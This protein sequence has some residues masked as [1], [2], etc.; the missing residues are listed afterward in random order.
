MVVKNYALIEKWVGSK[1]T[2]MKT[3]F[4]AIFDPSWTH[5]LSKKSPNK[6]FFKQHFS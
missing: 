1:V 6:K 3:T 2:G 5:V 4:F